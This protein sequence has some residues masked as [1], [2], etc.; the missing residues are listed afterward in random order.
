MELLLNAL[1]AA[2]TAAGLTLFVRACIDWSGKRPLLYKKPWGCNLCMSFWLATP[3][4]V[5]M[6][7][8][9][10]GLVIFPAYFITYALLE[11]FWVPPIPDDV[12]QNGNGLE[13]GS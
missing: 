8:L 10:S 4:S 5:A 6:F 7:G 1:G 11:S 3:S 9:Q 13:G 2:L 12:L